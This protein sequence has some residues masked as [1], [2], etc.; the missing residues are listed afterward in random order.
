[1]RGRGFILSGRVSSKSLTCF[2][3]PLSLSSISAPHPLS[4]A[5]SHSQSLAFTLVELLAV[6]AI[7]AIVAAIAFP[8][9]RTLVDRSRTA[10]CVSNLQQCS[11]LL[12]AHAADHGEYPPTSN[13]NKTDQ[14]LQNLGGIFSIIYGFEECLVCPA[15]KYHDVNPGWEGVPQR[16]RQ[17][18]YAANEVILP[19]RSDDATITPP[20]VTSLT[21]PMRLSRASQVI[22]LADGLQI[23]TGTK[24]NPAYV[25]P[26]FNQGWNT[27]A[28]N[29]QSGAETPLVEGKDVPKGQIP[30]RH[31]NRAN[32]LFC[33]GHV[34]SISAISDLKRKNLSIAY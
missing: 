20:K 7:I 1:M 9:Y 22:M 17:T 29:A 10:A 11:R 28:N 12:S 4:R 2:G 6:I 21:R 19:M 23:G 3:A 18:G 34:E 27:S 32:I 14:G 5:F 31:N 33:D 24:A 8:S 16:W 13:H 26:A 15:A 30:F 25:W